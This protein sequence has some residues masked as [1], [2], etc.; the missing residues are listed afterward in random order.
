M[1]VGCEKL[2]IP[3]NGCTVVDESDGAIIDD[4]DVLLEYEDKV[5]ILLGNADEWT[6]AQQTT[7]HQAESVNIAAATSPTNTVSTSHKDTEVSHEVPSFRVKTIVSK[8]VDFWRFTEALQSINYFD[9]ENLT[10]TARC[11]ISLQISEDQWT[12]LWANRKFLEFINN[13]TRHTPAKMHVVS[14]LKS[15]ETAQ[16]LAPKSLLAKYF[17][18]SDD[19]SATGVEVP[20]KLNSLL[21]VRE[22]LQRVINSG[23]ASEQLMHVLEVSISASTRLEREMM[24]ANAMIHWSSASHTFEMPWHMN[25]MKQALANIDEYEKKLRPR[26]SDKDRRNSDRTHKA[27]VELGTFPE[28]PH[29][30]TA[31]GVEREYASEDKKTEVRLQR[32]PTEKKMQRTRQ[33]TDNSHSAVNKSSACGNNTEFQFF[34]SSSAITQVST[35][36]LLGE[37]TFNISQMDYYRISAILPEPKVH[38]TKLEGFIGKILPYVLQRVKMRGYCK[39]QPSRLSALVIQVVPD[40]RH[41]RSDPF[42]PKSAADKAESKEYACPVS[43]LDCITCLLGSVDSIVARELLLVMSQFPMAF[44]LIMRNIANE[45]KYSLMTSLL[46]G[47]VVKWE[48]GSG[49]I[50][51]HSLFNDPFKLLVAVRLG[52]REVGKSAILN[53]ILAKEHTFSTKGEPGSEYGKPAT[54]DGSV[55][56]IWLTQE[57]C[58][59]NLWKSVVSQHYV[60]DD[61]TITLL[62]NL[63]GDANENTDIIALLN[64]CFQCRYLAFIMPNCTESQWRSFTALIPSKDHVPSIRVDPANYDSTS[65]NDILTSHIADDKTLHKVRSCLDKGLKS[66]SVVKCVNTSKQCANVSL[67]DGIE[68]KMSQDIIDFVAHNTCKLT[69]EHLQLQ[70]QVQSSNKQ[71]V[72]QLSTARPIHNVV[73]QFIGILQSQSAVMQRAVMHLENELSRLCNAETQ[74]K[75]LQLSQHKADL[76]KV[77]T[78]SQGNSKVTER[79]RKNVT[80]T[81]NVMD[82]MNLGVEHFFREVGYLYE[83]QLNNPTERDVLSLPQYVAELFLNGHPIELLDGDAAEVQ[84]LWLNAIFKVVAEKHPKLRVYVIS[85]LGLQSSGKSTLLNSLFACRFAVS[86][87]RCSRGLFMRLLFLDKEAAKAFKV[88]AVLLIDTEGLG[89]LEKMGDI[90]AEKKDRLLATFA[91]GISNL[92]IINVLGEY[93]KELTEILQIAVVT[94]TRLEQADIAP[95][96]LLVQHLLT[97]KNSEKLSQ[98]EEQFCE[99]IRNAID[100]ADKKDFQV[101]VSS[102]KCLRELFARIQNGTLLTQFHPYKDG[103]TANA[104]PSEAYHNDVVS[105]YENILGCC[106][107]SRSVFSF[108]KWRT[109]LES[110]WEC[111]IQEDFA[112]RF[113]NVKEIYDFID[114]GQRIANV[115]QAIDKAFG[116]HARK[117]IARIVILVQELH[118]KKATQNRQDFLRELENYIKCLPHGCTIDDSEK[119]PEC[120]DACGR[121]KKLYKYVKDQPCEIETQQTIANFIVVVQESTIRKLSQSFDAMVVQQGCCVEFDNIITRHLKD[122]LSHGVAGEFSE[123]KREDIIHEIFAELER[124]ARNQDRD[125]PVRAKIADAIKSDY[126]QVP[127]MMDRFN[128]SVIMFEDIFTGMQKFKFVR[129]L[130]QLV[131]GNQTTIEVEHLKYSIE[132]LLNNMLEQRQADCYE[133]G[134]VGELSPKLTSLLDSVSGEKKKLDPKQKKN[135]HVW[136]MQQFCRRMEDMQAA[137]DKKNKPSSILEQNKERYVQIINTRLEHG[138][139]VAAEGQIIGQHLLKVTQQKAIAAETMEKIRAVE[140]LV[141]TTNSQ[142]VRLKYLKHL[143]ENVKDGKIYAALAH[144]RNPTEQ[145]EAWYKDAVD[146]YRSESFGKTFTRTFKH[147]FSAVLREI[148]NATN[149]DE[150]LS[151]TKKYFAGLEFLYYQPSSNFPYA[152]TTDDLRVMKDEII[153]TMKENQHKFCTVDDESF[154]RPS[155]DVGV[156]SRLGCTARCRWCSALC[157]GQRGHES[158]QDETRKHHSSHQPQGLARVSYRGNNHLISRPCH[159]TTDETLVHFGEYVDRG[160]PWQVAKK[161]HFSDWKFDRHYISKFDELMRWFFQELHHSIAEKSE[162]QK[163]A[164]ADD[165]KMYNCNNLNYDDIMSRVEQEIN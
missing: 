55:E 23:N 50:I 95:D 115:K 29:R 18:V 31:R 83:L 66:C 93:I 42:S 12:C 122:H 103:A 135:I 71:T 126:R 4:D 119:C 70:L 9:L 112:L 138:F 123:S 130:E 106:E 90:E 91:M 15:N 116:S 137:W 105:L 47:I 132:C 64:H 68:T 87:G 152:A 65:A 38:E 113:K 125:V 114:R 16:K 147:E 73:R 154:S 84:T 82:S 99:A 89:S 48:S 96:I 100:L 28:S 92:T 45:G 37:Q 164:T 39:L 148:E 72:K 53:Q 5:L 1:M 27:T 142:K 75:R 35:T 2:G 117:R 86:I 11:L 58:K 24:A 155:D 59:D 159:E 157:W 110:Y 141:W 121:Q 79:I 61:S 124:T 98:S 156:M 165:L 46:R 67:A 97:E 104:P 128:N 136:T 41:E 107:S 101:G 151:I 21:E 77:M 3:D 144:F 102:A 43:R 129:G 133:D 20:K 143:A 120:K 81:L 6:P 34:S 36:V 54:V 10:A 57:T 161:E 25:T 49:K 146:E 69:K 94:M 26:P 140:G 40:E 63:H 158:N 19:N 62:G 108:N 139:S 76:R 150:I 88:D 127:D 149:S 33:L 145:M 7:S 74:K 78:N 111:V 32:H 160:I 52:Q 134:M 51:E 85:I 22:L 13:C 44:P 60:G 162:S 80:D 163:P 118:E 17:T 14:L 109:L 8:Q 56:F 30:L 153:K 131:G